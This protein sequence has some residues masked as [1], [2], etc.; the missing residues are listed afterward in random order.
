MKNRTPVVTILGHVDHGKTTLL[1]TIRNSRITKKEHGGITQKIGGYE[2]D[3]KISGYPTSKITFIDTPGHE[4]FSLLR[5]RGANVADIAILIIDAKDSLKPQ[6]IE[7]ISH[8]KSA[9]IP[10]IIALNKMDMPGANPAKVQKDL[11]KYEV[12]TELHGGKVPIVEIVATEGKGIPEL[13]EMILLISADQNLQFDPKHEPE[14]YIIE[15]KKDRRGVVITAVIKE[16]VLNVR[17]TIY[18]DKHTAKVRAIINDRGESI[19]KAQPSLPFELLGFTEAPEVGS[20]ITT[21]KEKQQQKEDVADVEET[22]DLQ[23]MYAQK[24]KGKT[25]NL[26]VKADSQGSL[27]AITGSLEGNEMISIILS[28]VGAIHKSDIFLAKTTKSIIVGFSVKPDTE[29]RQS[30]RQ[31]KVVIKTYNI[32]YELLEELLEVSDLLKEK[33]E[34]EKSTKGE[35]KIL[36]NFIIDGEKVYGIKMAKGKA[37]LGDHVEAYRNNNLIEKAKLISLKIRAK[38]VEEVRRGQEAGILLNPQLD[39]R[40]GDVIKFII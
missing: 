38:P 6:T 32:I 33:E 39:L 3:T 16:G 23:S 10:M 27:D 18:A 8:I 34:S 5:S 12:I 37:N 30:A 26:I 9:K 22:L 2:I 36:A 4:A 28:A 15:T 20:V 14:A 29:V 13:L 21:T 24:P 7:S 31:E 17:D 35:A 40:V 1:D 25:L 11:L 19:Q